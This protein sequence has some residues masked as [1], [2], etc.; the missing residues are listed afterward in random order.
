M[1]K[2][3]ILALLVISTKVISQTKTIDNAPK[4]TWKILIKNSNTKEVN[5]KLIGQN[6]IDNDYSIE[7]KDTDFFTLET[8]PKV[9][10]NEISSY[11]FKFIA[12]D[13]LIILT[14]M[15]RSSLDNN[16]L[17][18]I[19]KGMKGSILKEQFNIMLNF[20]KQFHNSEFDFITD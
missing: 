1:K 7:K 15:A 4:N 9:T 18:I 11:Y 16:Y 12:K 3:L 19:N 13:N 20:A 6:I 10:N 17:K 5:F 14:G 2:I 8:T